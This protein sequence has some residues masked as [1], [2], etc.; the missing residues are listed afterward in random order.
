VLL[1]AGDPV[2]NVYFPATGVCT[3][4][5]TMEDGRSMEVACVGREGVIGTTGL[6][7]A[8]IAP[9][10]AVI[11]IPGVSAY[12]LPGD[13]FAGEMARQAALYDRIRR[14]FQVLLSSVMQTAACNGLHTAH[15]RLARWLLE[16]ADRVGRNRLEVTQEL[17]ALLLGVR[18]ATITLIAGDLARSGLITFQRRRI[19]LLDRRR[20]EAF[21]CEC[22]R[23]VRSFH[24]Q[25]PY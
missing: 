9:A 20:L 15:Q 16:T 23:V 7:G 10:N 11:Q 22:Y 21:T 1:R 4:L 25:L 24:Q 6:L 8:E 12:V 13:V 18:R 19:T 2:K 5:A 17:L 3:L 14:Y